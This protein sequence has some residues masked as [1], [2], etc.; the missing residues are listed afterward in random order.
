[1]C[2]CEWMY[3]CEI[4]CETIA[5]IH[6][7]CIT[8]CTV[9]ILFLYRFIFFYTLFECIFRFFDNRNDV[10]IEKWE[11]AEIGDGR[12]G[13]ETKRSRLLHYNHRL[14]QAN[15]DRSENYSFLYHTQ[16]TCML[17]EP[18]SIY[19]LYFNRTYFSSRCYYLNQCGGIIQV[20]NLAHVQFCVTL[21]NVLIVH[22]AQKEDEWER[23]KS[24][25]RWRGDRERWKQ[26][27]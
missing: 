20:K 27:R 4:K 22:S 21:A 23:W 8:C 17:Y 6:L 26:R 19:F 24:R 14:P 12:R 10:E 11:D 9:F 1:M 25:D 5:N 7:N 18:R 2:E 15:I 16:M 3:P 13:G